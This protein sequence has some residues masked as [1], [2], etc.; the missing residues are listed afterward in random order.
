MHPLDRL[1]HPRSVAIVGASA[2]RDKL[3]GRP[4]A[5]LQRYGFTGTIYPINPRCDAIAGLTCYP[6]VQSLPAPPDVG[7]VLL[8]AERVQD[9]VRDLCKAGAA[10]AVILA[11]GF[12]EAGADGER[13]QRV[14]MAAAG[15]MRLLGPNT[16]GLVNITDKIALS[17]SN[18]LQIDELIEGNIGVVS[19]SGGILGSLLS[20]AFG[21]GIGFSKLIATGNEA[22]ID[23]SECIEYLIEDKSTAV[24]ALYLEGLRDAER[25]RAAAE[26]AAAAGKPIVV[27]KVGRSEA[28]VRAAVSHTGAL[29]GADRVY[30]ALF[31]QTGV[32]RAGL[33]ADLL[34][35]P[36]ALATGQTLAGNRVAIVT[37]TG[38][39][40]T[41]VA[42][43]CGMAGLDTPAPDRA[44]AERLLALQ[45]RD[46]SLDRNPIDVTLGGLRPDVLRSVIE[47][48]LDSP[49]YDAVIV[50]VG[51][52]GLGSPDLVAKPV[53]AAR[54]RSK[55]PL[56]V[57]VSPDAPNIVKHLNR[58]GVPAFGAPESCAAALSAMRQYGRQAARPK[59]VPVKQSLA[60]GAN[61]FASGPLN[62]A[63]SKALFARFGIP[64]VQEFVVASAREAEQAARKLN[65]N[66]VLKILSREITHKTEVGGV[67]LNVS[68]QDVARRCEEMQAAVTKATKARIEGFLVQETIANGVEMILGFHRDP[69]LGPTVLLG[70][71]GIAAELFND[72]TLRLPPLGR[73]DAE[74]MIDELKGSALLRGFRGRAKCDV[75][76]LVSAIVVFSEM[77]VE[78][79]DR[80]LEAEINPLFVML[81]R[82]GVRAG[83]GVV[84]LR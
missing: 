8:G 58:H 30:D 42:D 22:D 80:L 14:V 18:A 65:G 44:T 13:R 17:A 15:P 26:K 24:I 5:Y 76:A 19:Q 50:I 59:P 25:F 1:F 4:L 7:I 9:A 57:Y 36:A 10:A 28:G 32:I 39:A 79:D 37:S 69:Q 71:G 16:I 33:F 2:D 38:G 3:T 73:Q 34:D 31:R 52:S 27:F 49:G 12:A 84:V 81:E 54:A 62:E 43:S 83:D 60:L 48:L 67:I 11:S 56:L 6:D 35:I 20:R 72:T 55:K 21:R 70:F 78:L 51:S 68:P 74:E 40:A 63:E 64:S 41:L 53:I 46:A 45:I 77:V 75:E 47:L 23:V 61:N 29:A 66:V 82:Q